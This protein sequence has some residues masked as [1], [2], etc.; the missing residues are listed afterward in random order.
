MLER[1]TRRL[2]RMD[3]IVAGA[4]PKK[5]KLGKKVGGGCLVKKKRKLSGRR[6]GVGKVHLYKTIS[7]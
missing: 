1:H 4:K 5:Q 2:E 6:S 7:P 3:T